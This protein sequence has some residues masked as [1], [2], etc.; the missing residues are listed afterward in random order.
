MITYSL[1]S[2]INGVSIHLQNSMELTTAKSNHSIMERS[3]SFRHNVYETIA[4]ASC[5]SMAVIKGINGWVYTIK[6]PCPHRQ[7]CTQICNSFYLRILDSQT[8]HQPWLAIGALHVYPYRPSSIVTWYGSTLGLKVLWRTDY[9]YYQ[10]CGP[11]YCCC[12]A[13]L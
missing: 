12:A 3:A 10:R 8:I 9:E 13:M 2:Y 11:N 1:I 6:R 5:N 4:Q 7:T